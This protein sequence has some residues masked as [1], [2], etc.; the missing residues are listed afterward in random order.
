M[1]W[2]GLLYTPLIAT[3]LVCE[4]N[5]I[6]VRGLGLVSA[7]C[8]LGCLVAFGGVTP[9][10]CWTSVSLTL[11]GGTFSCLQAPRQVIYLEVSCCLSP[12]QPL[13]TGGHCPIHFSTRPTTSRLPEGVTWVCSPS[14]LEKGRKR[15][16]DKTTARP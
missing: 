4:Q 5:Q 9:T 10:P 1:Q 6:P 14:P 2:E 12:H 16:T 15:E 11:G 7:L 8:A 13:A 3:Q